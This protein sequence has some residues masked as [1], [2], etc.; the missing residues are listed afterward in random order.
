MTRTKKETALKWIVTNNNTKNRNNVFTFVIKEE[1]FLKII[2]AIY[3]YSFRGSE[4]LIRKEIA[5]AVESVYYSDKGALDIIDDLQY[6]SYYTI[7]RVLPKIVDE[8]IGEA[9]ISLS[10]P[11]DIKITLSLIDRS[12]FI[13]CQLRKKGIDLNRWCAQNGMLSI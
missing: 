3:R 2:D 13:V 9:L 8:V 6:I 7:N 1:T 5:E 4:D 11:K 12:G 10:A